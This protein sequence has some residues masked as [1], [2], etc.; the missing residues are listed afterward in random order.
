MSAVGLGWAGLMAPERCPAGETD[1][2][3]RSEFSAVSLVPALPGRVCA[4]R[5]APARLLTGASSASASTRR[6]R[7]LAH[8]RA[9][10]ALLCNLLH[11]PLE[12]YISGV[13]S[14]SCSASSSYATVFNL[15]LR[16]LSQVSFLWR[17]QS[18]EAVWF[19]CGFLL[20]EG[21]N[22]FIEDKTHP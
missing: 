4:A 3:T 9:L 19:G 10:R 20:H 14:I 7:A 13:S 12:D 17:A 15:C 11:L 18:Q 1:T 6:T 5:L 21:V 22:C 8:G 2:G 16:Q